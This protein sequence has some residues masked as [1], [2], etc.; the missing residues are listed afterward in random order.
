MADPSVLMGVDTLLGRAE[1]ALSS[2]D[3]P[4]MAKA[5]QAIIAFQNA[6]TAD[7]VF[8]DDQDEVDQ[9][10]TARGRLSAA[11]VALGGA[12]GTIPPPENYPGDSQAGSPAMAFLHSMGDTAQNGLDKTASAIGKAFNGGVDLAKEAADKLKTILVILAVGLSL[13]L[14]VFAFVYAGGLQ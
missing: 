1:S 2:N 14:I 7:W 12:T 8:P 10:E 13:A 6:H 11:W 3:A 4:T 9:L 5:G